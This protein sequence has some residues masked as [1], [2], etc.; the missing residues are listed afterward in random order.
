MDY[1]NGKI[2]KIWNEVNDK[3]YIGSTTQL[4][5]QRMA[6]HVNRINH[7]DYPIYIAM[8]EHGKDVFR[9]ELIENFPCN[10]KD[11]LTAREGFY[12]R[13]YDTFN[14]DKGYNGQIEGRTSK[15]YYQD[16][17]DK[18]KEY[19]KQYYQDNKDIINITTKNYFDNNKDKMKVYNDNY[20]KDNKDKIIEHKKEYYNNNKDKRKVYC[21]T[22]YDCECGSTNINFCSKSVHNK[23]VKHIMYIDSIKNTVTE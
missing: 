1:Q 5:C 16:N 19:Y 10:S 20:Y 2:Y 13:Q 14:K 15:E 12:I 7:K 18:H 22:K 6:Q 21:S 11:E 3:I 23:T 17:K 9:I 8:R 4:L